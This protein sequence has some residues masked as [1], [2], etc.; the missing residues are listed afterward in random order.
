MSLVRQTSVLA[1]LALAAAGVVSGCGPSFVVPESDYALQRALRGHI[2]AASNATGETFPTDDREGELPDL[3]SEPRLADYVRYAALR[4]PGLRATFERW[5]AASERPPQAGALPDPQLT[6]G[7]IRSPVEPKVGPQRARRGLAQAVPWRGKRG[8][9]REA[10]E[11]AARG[12]FERFGAARLRLAYMVRKAY[13]AYWLLA[14]R[15]E[16]AAEHLRLVT[17]L[18]AAARSRYAAGLSSHGSVVG[19][20]VELGKLEDRLRSLEDFRGAASARLRAAVGSSQKDG[21][22]PWPREAPP[23]EVRLPDATQLRE[24]ALARSP[25]IRAADMAVLR[26]EATERLAALADRPDVTVGLDYIFTGEA[27]G[28][29]PDS[30]KDAVAATVSIGLPLSRGKYRAARREA[31][32]M[33]AAAESER[34]AAKDELAAALAESLFALRDALRKRNLY[35]HTLIAKARESLAVSRRSFEAGRADHAS[36][37]D[38]QRTLLEFELAHLHALA[39]TA[40]KGAEIE[41]LAGGV[42]PPVIEDKG[43]RKEE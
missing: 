2:A 24:I 13:W 22:L 1:T 6:R 37:I 33:H 32:A 18:E 4:S 41:M 40:V 23:D 28:G 20:Q 35:G 19:L 29:G 5:R 21:P 9:R 38:A 8:L 15:I 14:R 25:E 27:G 7:G 26:A 10:A 3:E 34:D 30:G 17:Q 12:A 36:L 16:T 31:M 42:V 11:H 39:E 43:P